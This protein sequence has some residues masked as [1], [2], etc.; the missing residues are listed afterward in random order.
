METREHLI[1]APAKDDAGGF[2]THCSCGWRSRTFH[3][4]RPS[5]FD[6][7]VDHQARAPADDAAAAWIER[8]GNDE[9]GILAAAELSAIA[10]LSAKAA[11]EVMAFAAA[12]IEGM[13]MRRTPPGP[14]EP[15]PPPPGQRFA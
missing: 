13:R 15:P 12:K 10:D 5:A 2:T 8:W 1:S 7:A 4:D 9:R 11:K 6:A 3:P 14:P